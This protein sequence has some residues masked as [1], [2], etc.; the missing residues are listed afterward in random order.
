MAWLS[1]ALDLLRK[2]DRLPTL[3]TKHADPIANLKERVAK[4]ESERD[5]LLVE[6]KAAAASAASSAVAQTIA[7]LA[8]RVGGLEERTREQAGVRPRRKAIEK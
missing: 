2:A 4:L 7:D 8:R 6:A 5:L 3:E 1:T